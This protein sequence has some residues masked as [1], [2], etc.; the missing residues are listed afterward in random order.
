MTKNMQATGRSHS[1]IMKMKM[2][3]EIHVIARFS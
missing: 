3:V 1:K 2:L